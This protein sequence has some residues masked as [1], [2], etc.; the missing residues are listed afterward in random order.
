MTWGGKA[1]KETIDVTRQAPDAHPSDE[2]FSVEVPPGIYP[3][4]LP[5]VY[6]ALRYVE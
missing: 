1:L 6:G 2:K 5:E 3:S 4:L